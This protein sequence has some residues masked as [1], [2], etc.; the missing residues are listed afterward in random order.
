MRQRRKGYSRVSHRTNRLQARRDTVT[1]ARIIPLCAA[2]L[3]MACESTTPSSSLVSDDAI[4][5][6]VLPSAGEAIAST[7]ASMAGNQAASSLPGSNVH[8]DLPA[9]TTN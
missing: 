3:V 4:E 2:L 8:T 5:A 6:D 1:S 7:L 9:K